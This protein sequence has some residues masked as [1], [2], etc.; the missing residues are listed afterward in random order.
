MNR[1]FALIVIGII[2]N[3]LIISAGTK[4]KS[5]PVFQDYK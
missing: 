2:G 5:S 4:K 1:L 3:P